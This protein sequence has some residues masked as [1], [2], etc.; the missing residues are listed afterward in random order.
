MSDMHF[1]SNIGTREIHNNFIVFYSRIIK[2]LY[3]TVNSLLD[4]TILNLDLKESFL[5]YL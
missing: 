3:E 4:E 1:L 5:V 2:S